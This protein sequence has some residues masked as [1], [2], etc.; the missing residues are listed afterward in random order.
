MIGV[1][2]ILLLLGIYIAYVSWLKRGV[3]PRT[4]QTALSAD[5]VRTLFVDT[6]ARAGWQVV[7]DGN[8]LVAQSSLLTGVR[9][10]IGLST[11][12]GPNGVEVDVRPMRLQ[13]KV[14]S[15]VPT[16]GHTLR[17][18]MDSFVSA[19]RQSDPN[20]QLVSR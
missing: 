1:L 4:F 9:Q 7:D 3:K 8:P 14:L 15:R 5:Q 16:K 19:V 2:V 10:Q 20:L 11:H 17:I 18:R 13:V 12:Q 6:V